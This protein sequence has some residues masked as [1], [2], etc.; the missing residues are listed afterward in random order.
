[1]KIKVLDLVLLITFF[2]AINLFSAS[3]EKYGK[4]LAQNVELQRRL[5]QSSASLKASLIKSDTAKS[6]HSESPD[7]EKGLGENPLDGTG[8]GYSALAT[9]I[10]RQQHADEE[11]R[12]SPDLE[13]GLAANPLAGA[14]SGH[15]APIR[16]RR[17]RVRQRTA[18]IHDHAVANS[19]EKLHNTLSDFLALQ[20]THIERQQHAGEDRNKFESRV[21]KDVNRNKK[22]AML[23]T[24]FAVMYTTIGFIMQNWP[25]VTG[26]FGVGRHDKG[27]GAGGSNSTTNSTTGW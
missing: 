7:L 1:M 15:G 27:P 13:Q 11:R 3:K 18:S 24:G 26:F 12:Q 20:A 17:H 23:G 5:A 14:G 8:V 10:E 9:P 25:A 2:N 21:Y 19:V 4:K 16:S 22:I 6:E